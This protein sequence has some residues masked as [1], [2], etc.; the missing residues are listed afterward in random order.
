MLLYGN[1][2]VNIFKNGGIYFAFISCQIIVYALN[3]QQ[4]QDVEKKNDAEEE[5]KINN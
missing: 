3:R 2:A 5:V 4:V 1:I